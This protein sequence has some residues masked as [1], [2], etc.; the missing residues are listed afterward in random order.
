MHIPLIRVREKGSSD[1]G[2]LIGTNSHDHLS[3]NSDGRISYLNLQN[4]EGTGEH[5]IY[6]FVGVN[7][8]CMDPEIPLVS[9]VEGMVMVDKQWLRKLEKLAEI[10]TEWR[11][12]MIDRAGYAANRDE[13]QTRHV[14]TKKIT[15]E[16]VKAIEALESSSKG[17][18]G[19]G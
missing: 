17:D 9:E 16:L 19:N 7:D 8:P 12:G 15:N 13:V 6:E 11:E 5:G 18:I 14:K 1:S 4:C 2:R 10:A 3:V